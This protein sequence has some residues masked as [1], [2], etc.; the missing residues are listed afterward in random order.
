MGGLM[1]IVDCLLEGHRTLRSSLAC[2]AVLLDG[3]SGVGWDDCAALDR[4]RFSRELKG[5]F[6]AFKA[7][8]AMEDAYLTRILHQIEM[9]PDLNAA[10]AEGHRA[11]AEMTKLFGAVA[12]SCDGEHVYRLRTVLSR[13]S[14]ELET[15][16]SYEEKVVF[17]KLRALLPDR[18]LREL[19]RRAQ[20]ATAAA[21]AP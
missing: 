10:I 16:L 7:H 6:A 1:D 14:E 19:G 15:H 8:E 11:V 21:A 20:A 18:L 12:A 13:L 2:M 9:E 5:F 3:P 4:E 17:P